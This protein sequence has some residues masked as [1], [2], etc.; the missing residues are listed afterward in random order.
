MKTKLKTS[1]LIL[2]VL[3]AIN[4][5]AQNIN[6]KVGV[7]LN[8]EI[9]SM[10]LNSDFSEISTDVFVSYYFNP[11]IQMFVA[12]RRNILLNTNTNQFENRGAGL[13]GFGYC[14]QRDSASNFSILIQA[15]YGNTLNKSVSYKEHIFD[16]GINFYFYKMFYLG[17][18]L[19]SSYVETS[20]FVNLPNQNINWYWRLGFRLNMGKK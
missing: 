17:T 20:K 18:G 5:N 6:P 15:M 10:P 8:S 7:G 11:K 3:S 9:F 19:K 12:N 2:A 4:V 1:L 13:I 14:F 16:L